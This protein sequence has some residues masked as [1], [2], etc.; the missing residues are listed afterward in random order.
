MTDT[1]PPDPVAE[2]APFQWSWT[3]IA[4]YL[5][6]IALVFIVA[7]TGAV[8]AVGVAKAILV[9]GFDVADWASRIETDGVVLA[10]ASFAAAMLCVPLVLIL[11]HRHEPTPWAFLG[12]RPVRG[13]DLAI[14]CGVMIA[15]IVVS[16]SINVWLLHRPLVPPFL[17]DSYVSS[18]K[19]LFLLAALV[20]AAP[21]VEEL[22]V[23]GFLF[24]T[25]RAKGVRVGWVVAVTTL[26]FAVVHTQYDLHDLVIV[27][28]IGLLLGLARARY[29]SIVPSTA[30]HAISN[31]IAFFETMYVLR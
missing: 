19:P 7:Q 4:G 28:L 27:G 16:D 30:M 17:R 5:A 15:F 14:A 18:G 13:R 11:V 23:R 12:L 31:A 20:L 26:I 9:P 25:L 8:I 10:A 3:R 21:L 22:M 2:S 29:D 6:S 24:G 1:P